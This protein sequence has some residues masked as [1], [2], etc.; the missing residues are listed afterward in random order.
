RGDPQR[1]QRAD[2]EGILDPVRNLPRVYEA[3]WK[4]ASGETSARMAPVVARTVHERYVLDSYGRQ[5]PGSY[6]RIP[7]LALADRAARSLQAL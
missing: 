6:M 7:P 1:W 2:G 4:I 5:P 3:L